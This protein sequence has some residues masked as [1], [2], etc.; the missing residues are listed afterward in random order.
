[1]KVPNYLVHSIIATLCCCLPF[2][3]VA[4]V[5]SAQVN[6]KLAAGDEAGARES[7]KKARTWIIVAFCGFIVLIGSSL[8]LSLW[9]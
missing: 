9:Q 4:M 2:G 3:I 8:A 6:T 1:M 5:Y 7:S